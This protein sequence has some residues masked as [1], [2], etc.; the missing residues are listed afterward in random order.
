M[1]DTPSATLRNPLELLAVFGPAGE[2]CVTL[3]KC[4]A[5]T[6]DVPHNGYILNKLQGWYVRPRVP[7]S[8]VA[9]V[10]KTHDSSNADFRVGPGN[11]S[12][13]ASADNGKSTPSS[14]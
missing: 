5:G 6:P 2:R 7:V 1:E 14:R 4:P 8:L 11:A 10:G 12:I 9:G 3:C 13:W